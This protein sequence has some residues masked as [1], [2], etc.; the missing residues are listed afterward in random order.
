MR[1]YSSYGLLGDSVKQGQYHPK[2]VPKLSDGKQYGTLQNRRR[3]TMLF[4]YSLKK[5]E[6]K[7]HH[8]ILATGLNI[9]ASSVRPAFPNI[10][11]DNL[12]DFCNRL[13]GTS[14]APLPAI[15]NRTPMAQT[16]E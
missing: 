6:Y 15:Q 13:H 12:G 7:L 10:K 9:R 5:R 1:L 2:C 8:G 14:K 16:F 11:S 4:K 3:S